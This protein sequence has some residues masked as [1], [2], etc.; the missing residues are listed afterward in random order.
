APTLKSCV[1]VALY[2]GNNAMGDK[3]V[4]FLADGLSHARGLQKLHLNDN[5]ARIEITDVGCHRLATALGP[6][7]VLTTLDLCHNPFGDKGCL[8][9][10]TYLSH[11]GCSLRYLSVAG[12]LDIDPAAWKT[13]R[14]CGRERLGWDPPRPGDDGAVSLAAALMSPHGCPLRG[15]RMAN[16]GMRTVGAKAIATAF[17]ANCTLETVDLSGNDFG[18]KAGENVLETA[19]ELL[20]GEGGVTVNT[21]VHTIVLRACGLTRQQVLAVQGNCSPRMIGGQRCHRH[22]EQEAHPCVEDDGEN[23]DKEGLGCQT[24]RLPWREEKRLGFRAA[25]LRDWLLDAA[26]VKG[27]VYPRSPS[28]DRHGAVSFKTSRP[29]QYVNNGTP[30]VASPMDDGLQVG[31]N[32]FDTR[33]DQDQDLVEPALWSGLLELRRLVAS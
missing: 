33:E 21:A 31:E 11:P 1:I 2:L 22:M 4:T 12:C 25:C 17:C 30:A 15:L 10:A 32:E 29:S 28:L 14:V 18:C 16:A 23:A 24:G 26:R 5:E 27:M 19:A 3:G 7:E 13:I 20:S 8:A 6:L 9:L